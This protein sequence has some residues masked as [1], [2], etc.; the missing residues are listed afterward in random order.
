M[1]LE[2]LQN[3]Q[4]PAVNSYAG[5]QNSRYLD[6]KSVYFDIKD[7]FNAVIHSLPPMKQLGVRSMLV[8]ACNDFQKNYPSVK[9]FSDLDTVESIYVPLSDI[10]IDSTIQRMLDLTWVF[11]VIENFRAVQA[12]AIQVY[13]VDADVDFKYQA[14]GK[15]GLFASWDGQHTL[16]AF[17]IIAVLILKQNPKDVMVPVNIYKISKKAEIRENFVSGNSEIGKKLLDTIDLFMQMI[18]GV[19][20]DGS[21]NP[22]WREAELKQQYLEQADLFVTADKFGD[23]HMPGAISRM[24]EINKYTSDI[25]RKFCLYTTTFSVPRPI[26]SQ[27]IE[28]MCAWFDMAKKDGIDYTDDQVFSL[29][30]H[31]HHLF[32]ANFHET[33]TF[34]EK[35]R[36]AYSNWHEK[37]WAGSVQAPTRINFTK[38][39]RNGGT[40]LW[41]Q[42]SKTWTG[43]PIPSLRI[44]TP[45]IPNRKDLF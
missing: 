37:Y 39:W 40:F 22:V 1:T 8:K 41:Y 20:L 27:E 18:Y 23:T 2:L 44:D 32:D 4:A 11:R 24:Q 25:I 15:R 35:A 43:G 31:L 17:Y 30:M 3:H 45:F 28:I 13:P 9:Q 29:G 38:N 5:K 12:S 10:L 6:T 34:W 42:L 7:R 36:V 14:H 19:R 16:A 21:T 33:S 26:A